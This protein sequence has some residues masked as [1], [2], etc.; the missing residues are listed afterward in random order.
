MAES[1]S[2]FDADPTLL[3][4]SQKLAQIHANQYNETM[5]DETSNG[6]DDGQQGSEAILASSATRQKK[7][8]G[9]SGEVNFGDESAFPSLGGGSA[10]TKPKSLWGN[11]RQVKATI[12]TPSQVVS[13]TDLVTEVLKLEG[14]QQQARSLGKSQTGTIVYKV[15][16]TTGTTIQ[17]STAQKTGTTT[18][19]IKG[20]PEAVQTAR[21]SLLKELGKQVCLKPDLTTHKT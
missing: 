19:L 20:R 15:Q 10:T 5:I 3:A 4:P 21:K 8:N 12:A 6:L 9:T 7:T 2:V 13:T 14:E 11:A 16:K 18:F 1:S 17:M